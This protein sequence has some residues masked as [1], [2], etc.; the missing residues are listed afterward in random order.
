VAL[1]VALVAIDKMR[2]PRTRTIVVRLLHW[3]GGG[4]GV[5][6]FEALKKMEFV[7]CFER[8]CVKWSE[9]VTV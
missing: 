7:C 9:M 1:V 6:T 4:G 8:H 3:A 5:I 2:L